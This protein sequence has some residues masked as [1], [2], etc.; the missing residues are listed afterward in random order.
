M[1]PRDRRLHADRDWKALFEEGFS[2]RGPLLTFRIRQSPGRRRVGVSVGR[3][4]GRAVVRNR[5]KR[6]LR[7][8][9]DR[10]WDRLPEADI[11]LLARPEAAA[12][13]FESLEE[14]FLSVL[15]RVE[16]RLRELDKRDEASG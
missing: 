8:L 9:A 13:G 10:H 15:A 6:R 5:L 2:V 7:A 14:E 11:G 3:K 1:L 16:R 12:V 4:V